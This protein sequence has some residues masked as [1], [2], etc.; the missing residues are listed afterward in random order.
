[1]LLNTDVRRCRRRSQGLTRKWSDGG[2]G[3]TNGTENS[4]DV[5][6]VH[7]GQGV[8]LRRNQVLLE[9]LETMT[10]NAMK[11]QSRHFS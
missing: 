5:G 6:T 2:G 11:A 1:M 8:L 9:N 7:A 10:A 4:I 3:I